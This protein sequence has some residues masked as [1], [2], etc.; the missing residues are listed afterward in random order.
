M[1]RV[2]FYILSDVGQDARWRFACRLAYKALT[3]GQHIH[4]HTSDA[5]QQQSVDQLMWS[6]PEHQF[7]PHACANGSDELNE[8]T[9]PII[10]GYEQPQEHF[11]QVLINLDESVPGFFGRFERVIEII[12]DSV[13]SEGRDKYKYYRDRGYPLFHHDMEDWD[14]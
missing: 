14:D 13:K 5:N 2:D 10:I 8:Q 6:Y 9:V 1:T 3:S 4:V 7:L 11:D 12:V